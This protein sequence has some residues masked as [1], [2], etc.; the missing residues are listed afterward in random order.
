VNPP[1]DRY[2]QVLTTT[3]VAALHYRRGVNHLLDGTLHCALRWFERATT[4]NPGFAL[5][6]VAVTLTQTALDNRPSRNEAIDTRD[7]IAPGV[8]RRERQHVEV[9]NGLMGIEASRAIALGREHLLEYPLDLL[10][11]LAI[12]SVNPATRDDLAR[13]ISPAY[14]GDP[15]FWNVARG[16]TILNLSPKPDG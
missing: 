7:L 11:F 8:S 1:T 3:K 14:R 16:L 13:R 12:S 4:H 15:M 10:V 6:Q 9:L 2:G 5:A